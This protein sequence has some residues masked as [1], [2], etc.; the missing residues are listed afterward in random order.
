VIR[1]RHHETLRDALHEPHYPLL[2]QRLADWLD[3]RA[4]R[5]GL[6]EEAQA[7]LAEPI[8]EFATPL[9]DRDHRRVVKRGAAFAE[10]ST[11]QRHTLRIRIKELRYALDFFASLYP[12]AAGKN[13]LNALS[14]LQDCLGVMNDIAVARRLLDEAGVKPLV[15]ARQV[16]EGWY[17]CRMEVHERQF[18]DE[19]AHFRETERPWK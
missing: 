4:W 9:L 18:G 10:L 14:R 17:G 3:Q 12:A 5:K 16:I 6:D 7:R 1:E 8:P 13:L 11:E 19:W 15:P 2:R